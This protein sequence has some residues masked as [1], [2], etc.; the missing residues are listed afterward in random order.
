M[1]IRKGEGALAKAERL[2]AQAL[3][4]Q[5]KGALQKVQVGL[6]TF[7]QY[8]AT[9]YEHLKRTMA[10]DGIDLDTITE[11]DTK[12][13]PG[14]RGNGGAN[15]PEVPLMLTD[16]DSE[17]ATPVAPPPAPAT[18]RLSSLAA[19][20]LVRF[21][22]G[23]EPV[24]FS[25]SALRALQERGMRAPPKAVL[26]Q[27][28][29][30]CTN[31]R[32]DSQVRPPSDE[33][34]IEQITNSMATANE[35]HGRRAMSLRLPPDWRASGLYEVVMPPANTDGVVKIRNKRSGLERVVPGGVL[36]GHP[37]DRLYIEQNYSEDGAYLTAEG[38]GLLNFTVSLLFSNSRVESL[39]RTPPAKRLCT[40]AGVASLTG[41]PS[42]LGAAGST[43]ASSESPSVGGAMHM[44]KAT[45]GGEAPSTFGEAAG[46]A[47][48]IEE[49]I[50]PPEP[51]S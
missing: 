37:T 15:R 25:R 41:S 23:F 17:A 33:A 9:A 29:E 3:T 47:D 40:S 45:C 49:D 21:M 43:A 46:T 50:V 27:L 38:G 5:T 19:A 36:L 28:I 10:R 18:T 39:C 51:S 34:A 48:K 22:E 8:T 4:L 2:Q 13:A 31:M 14:K 32:G 6:R 1:P 44:V 20:M 7:P 35:N 30:F 12:S 24:V 16:G 11:K 26:L 42:G